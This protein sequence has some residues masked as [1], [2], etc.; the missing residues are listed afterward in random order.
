MISVILTLY[1]IVNHN[2]KTYEKLDF[3]ISSDDITEL[4]NETRR[5]FRQFLRIGASNDL[6]QTNT[7]IFTHFTANMLKQN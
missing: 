4:S 5:D 2:F 7:H 6:V 3:V 1:T